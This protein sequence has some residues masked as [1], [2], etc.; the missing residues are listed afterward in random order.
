MTTEIVIRN[1][2]DQDQLVK[3]LTDN[4][5]PGSFRIIKNGF[6]GMDDWFYYENTDDDSNAEIDFDST[7][8]AEY[9]APDLV[10]V[11]RREGD[12]TMFALK[13]TTAI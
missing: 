6:M 12:A 1:R 9:Q 3:W 10:F 5:G 4:I 7:D 11:F 8:A 13:W 2:E